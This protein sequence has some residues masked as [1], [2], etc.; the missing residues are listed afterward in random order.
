MKGHK[1]KPGVKVAKRRVASANRAVNK[2]RGRLTKAKSEL[3]DAEVRAK[4]RKARST[5]PRRGT[6]RSTAKKK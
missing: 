1:S 6:S 2:A 4:T 3:C 5:A